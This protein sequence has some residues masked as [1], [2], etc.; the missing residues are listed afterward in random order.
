MRCRTQAAERARECNIK[1]T[2]SIKA[3]RE[4]WEEEQGQLKMEK[5][6]A[7]LEK[8]EK[9][10]QKAQERQNSYVTK[11]QNRGEEKVTHANLKRKK[12]QAA[13]QHRTDQVIF[14]EWNCYK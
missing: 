12:I 6:E 10:R 11:L 3:Q 14:H 1:E 13:E 4:K 5:Y 8:I 7:N 2:F 9:G